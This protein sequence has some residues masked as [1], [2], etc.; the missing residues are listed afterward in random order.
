MSSY[1]HTSA[2]TVEMFRKSKPSVK[3][4]VTLLDT[5]VY[6]KNFWFPVTERLELLQKF[7]G[8]DFLFPYQWLFTGMCLPL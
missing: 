2:N 7:N 6:I 4:H 1:Q 3:K 8:N 5:L